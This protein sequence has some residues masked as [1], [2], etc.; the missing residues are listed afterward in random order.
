VEMLNT[1]SS[2]ATFTTLEYYFHCIENDIA[3][4]ISPLTHQP[5]PLQSVGSRRSW[6]ALFL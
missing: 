5:H 1:F 4:T 6:I 3:V 2:N